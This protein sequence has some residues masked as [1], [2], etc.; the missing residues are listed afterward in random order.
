MK[1]KILVASIAL[2]VGQCYAQNASTAIWETSEYYKSGNHRIINSSTAWSRGYTG[3]GSTIAILDSGLG[4][5]NPE[6]SNRIKLSKDFTSSGTINDTVGHGTHVAGIAAA[7]RNNIGVEGVAF[8]AGLL[9]GKI[10]TNGIVL[11]NTALSGVQWASANGA[12]VANL[13]SNFTLSQTSLK[14]KLIAPGVY[15]TSFT[16]SGVTTGGLNAQQWANAMP[17]NMVLVV[18][19]GN[20]ST[21]WSGGLGQLATATDSKGNLILGGRVIIAGNWNGVNNLG[22]GSNGAATLCQVVVNNICQDKYQT[23][24]FYLLAPGTGITSTVPTTYNK[25]GVATMTG[26][27]MSAPAISGSVAIIRQMWPQMTGSNIAQ[28]LLQ[29]ANKNIPNYNK[30]VDGQ[31]LLDLDRAT[32]PVGTLGIPTTGRL[33]G[34]VVTAAQPLLVTNGSASTG[35]ISNIVVLD[36]FQR[37]FYIKSKSLTAV[38]QSSREFNV[39]QA[40]MPYATKNNYS[41]FNN[42]NT[43]AG[44]KIDNID[45]HMYVDNSPEAKNITPLMMEIGYTAK[46]E[47][48]DIRIS[49]GAFAEKATWLGNAVNGFEGG[50]NN[51]ASV[52]QFL[53]LGVE[54]SFADDYKVH[55]NIS[56]GVTN[57]KAHSANINNIGPILSYSWSAGVEK[58]LSKSDSIGVMMYQPVSVYSAKANITAPVGLDSD[59]NIVQNS[60]ANLAADVLERRTGFYY[61]ID[62]RKTTK[63]MTFIEYR[64]NYKGQEGV[65]DKVVGLAINKL[66]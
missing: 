27:S 54:K 16:N 3:K 32:R 63:V 25:T 62:D 33:S 28:L 47:W 39:M 23:W 17:G 35:K 52:T 20:D 61:K 22:P 57:T 7:A 36:D 24:Q 43:H 58:K 66:F 44:T 49:G 4:L 29:T 19:A 45:F 6:F 42:Y 8:D 9:I 2:M 21:A 53:G 30:Y 1:L 56:H 38:S 13:S 31:G 18:A 37:D 48:A 59:F 14:A 50:G 11:S 5:S 12:D 26:T 41:Q 55:A 15:S 10:T 65:T 51:S 60:T 40:M 64:N 46:S 34:A